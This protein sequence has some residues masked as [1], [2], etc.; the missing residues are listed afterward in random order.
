VPQ[1]DLNTACEFVKYGQDVQLVNC[2]TPEVRSP[3][4]VVASGF[5][6]GESGAGMSL[7]C[8]ILGEQLYTGLG[9]GSPVTASRFTDPCVRNCFKFRG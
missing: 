9:P 6:G 1:V 3:E 7:S 5:D 2:V 4:S 8:G